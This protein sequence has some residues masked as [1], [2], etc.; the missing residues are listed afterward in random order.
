MFQFRVLPCVLWVSF[1]GHG[2]LEIRRWDTPMQM[3]EI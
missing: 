3:I 1:L 2:V